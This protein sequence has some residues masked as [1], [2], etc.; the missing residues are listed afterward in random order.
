MSIV[1]LVK[2]E[3]ESGTRK[4]I[5]DAL[6]LIQ[7]EFPA[8]IK[9]VVI[10]PN[11]YYYRDFTTGETTDPSFIVDLVELIRDKA[12]EKVAISIVES[13]ASAM[14]CKYVFRMLGY[15]KTFKDY[16]NVELVNL[17]ED[18]GKEVKVNAKGQ[19]FDFVLPRTIAEADLRIN[20]PKI[21]YMEPNKIS[22][23][24]K[25]IY[26]CNP[27]AKKFQ[28]HTKLDEAIV[29]LN[30]IMKFDLAI[31]DGIIVS[32][33]APRKL[34]LVMCSR[35]PVSFDA[36]ASK[37]AGVNPKS[38]GH[39]VLAQREGLGKM[40]FALKGVAPSVFEKTFPRKSLASKIMTIGYKFALKTRLL[41]K[42]M[43]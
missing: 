24:L 32:G 20:V 14:K 6:N 7:Y 17:S 2:A 26:G 30:K 8:D 29:G 36:V 31:L 35:D 28:Y 23:A 27:V 21:K 19:S 15:E 25:N 34:N 40:S 4:A 13:D 37:I 33:T 1:G 38:V 10:K 5:E 41:D 11:L 43:I 12:S 9:K 42:D 22:C 3:E 16:E 39:V 18:E